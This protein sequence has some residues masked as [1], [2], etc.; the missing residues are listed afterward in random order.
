MRARRTFAPGCV[1]SHRHAGPR[2]RH[3]YPG[4]HGAA[5][6][7]AVAR[8]VCGHVPCRPR[9]V[10]ACPEHSGGPGR[11]H[12]R[13]RQFTPLHVCTVVPAAGAPPPS[14]ASAPCGSGAPGC[15]GRPA[16]P[17]RVPPQARHHGCV[18]GRAG[19]QQARG[20]A[21]SRARKQHVAHAEAGV[22][23]VALCTRCWRGGQHR[24]SSGHCWRLA[25]RAHVGG[26]PRPRVPVLCALRPCLLPRW[27]NCVAP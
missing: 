17:S 21:A 23:G 15:P 18:A 1:G 16:V 5:A 12:A 14:G 25:G 9:C 19:R 27:R 26:C 2:A 11:H 13:L 4:L 10:C 6:A 20:A 24:P 7:S 3:R 22:I 8:A